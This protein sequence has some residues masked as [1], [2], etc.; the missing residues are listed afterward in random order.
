[1]GVVGDTALTEGEFEGVVAIDIVESMDGFDGGVDI[2][3]GTDTV[4]FDEFGERLSAD[5]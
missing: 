2:G 3:E 1:M 5:Q 4:D